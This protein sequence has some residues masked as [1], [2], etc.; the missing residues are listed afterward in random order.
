[1]SISFIRDGVG[2][3]NLARV[4][5][6]NRIYTRSVIASQTQEAMRNGD[7]FNLNTGDIALSSADA[8]A[9]IYMKNNETR[10]FHITDFA[11]GIGV[12][13]GPTEIAKVVLIRNPTSGTIIS[14]AVAVDMNQN[15]N[16]GSAAV[17]DATAYK[18]AEGDTFTSGD[19]AAQFFVTG[20]GRLFASLDFV[21]P[22]GA[23]IGITI[24]LNDSTGGLVYAALIG[25]LEHV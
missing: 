24:D 25:H 20:N 2:S 14:N 16:F 13:P 9:I 4:D 10:G 18:G 15:R 12:L 6:A 11:I 22:Q 5:S 17:I 21:L 19:D 8:S 1:M 7:A 23:S 3:G